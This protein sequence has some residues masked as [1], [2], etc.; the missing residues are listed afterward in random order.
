[1]SVPS[2]EEI[3]GKEKCRKLK[4]KLSKVKGVETNGNIERKLGEHVETFTPD[5][6]EE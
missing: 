2:C 4:E 3:F 5:S 1:M 6:D